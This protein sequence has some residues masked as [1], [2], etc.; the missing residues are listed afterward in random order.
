[1]TAPARPDQLDPATLSALGR[2]ELVA[3][4][5][6]DGFLTGLHRSARKGFSVEFAEHRPYFPGDD[7]R[8]VDWRISARSDRWVV[9]EY[10]EETNLRALLLIDSS[11]S[12]A[13]RGAPTRLTKLEYANRLGAAMALLLLR[14]RVALVLVVQR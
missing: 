5:I 2:L 12:M 6:A 7:L 1:M 9:K 13:W 8:Y 11:A 10:E 14:Q 4:W 3:R